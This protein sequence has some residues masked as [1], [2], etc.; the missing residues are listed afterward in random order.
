MINYIWAFFIILGIT[1][2]IITNNISVINKTLITSGTSAIELIFKLIPLMCLWL[3]VMKIA[4]DSNLINILSKHLSKIIS[5]LFPELKG[6]TKSITYIS[7]N[8][9]LNMLGVGNA[10]TPFGL[11]AMQEMQK[12]NKNKDTASRSMITFLVINTS[13]VTLIPS[14]IISLRVLNNSS[15]PTSIVPLCI[16]STFTSSLIGLLL[17]RLFYLITRKKYANNI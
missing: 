5:P 12:L 10:A 16:I 1:Y 9:I 17:D 6:D 3:G 15:N 7:S 4:E 13:S 11:K 8:I 2:G 14:T